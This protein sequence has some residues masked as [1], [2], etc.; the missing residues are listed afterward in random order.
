MS[1]IGLNPSEYLRSKKFCIYPVE[2]P[3]TGEDSGPLMA[4]LAV[5][6]E[7][8][9]DTYKLIVVD[10]ISNLASSSQEQSVMG[11]FSSCKRL[12]SQGR[13]VVVVAHSS[14]FNAG[15]LERVAGVCE[16][17]IRLQTGK[18]MKRVVRVA[19]LLKVNDIA[20]QE[21]N[22]INF[23]VSPGVGIQIIPISKA[24]A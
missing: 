2:E 6:I 22:A 19:E 7:R 12:C 8:I 11:F 23:E 1:S 13:T 21:N 16:T 9:S 17:H 5:D 4:A 18:I 20:L 15:L 3:N 10:A 14:G 24:K